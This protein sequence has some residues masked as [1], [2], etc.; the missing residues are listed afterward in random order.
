MK[1]YEIRN[2][3][4]TEGVAKSPDIK[5]NEKG[6]LQLVL[7]ADWNNYDVLYVTVKDIYQRELF[8]W[9]FPISGP[10]KTGERMIV[11]E[12]DAKIYVPVADTSLIYVNVK[13]VSLVFNELNGKI[14]SVKNKNGALPFNNGPVIEDGLN[15]FK[16]IKKYWQDD[17]YIIESTYDKKES[18][19]ILKWTIYPSG[20]VQIEVNYFPGNYFTNFA[21]VNFSLP[22]DQIK[23]VTY[24]LS[25]I[26][27]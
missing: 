1:R 15:N 20:W 10:S 14:I 11:K 16:G 7:P 5:P 8:T 19:N 24:M 4:E 27:I 22:E 21:G 12:G 6:V 23:S 3:K 17:K 18:Y 25:L 26:H 2:Q 9:S 13:D